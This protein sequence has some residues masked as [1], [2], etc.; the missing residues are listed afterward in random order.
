MHQEDYEKA[1]AE[2][3]SAVDMDP[4]Y[5]DGWVMLGDAN[6]LAGRWEAAR[7]AYKTALAQAPGRTDVQ[8]SLAAVEAS[9]T[10]ESTTTP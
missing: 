2:A 4:A 1:I 6:R 5:T 7:D 9:L 3:K 10:G 8:Q